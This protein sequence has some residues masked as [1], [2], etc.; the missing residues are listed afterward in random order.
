MDIEI[1][2]IEV[3]TEHKNSVLAYF[4]ATLASVIKIQNGTLAMSGDGQFCL[5]PFP[6]RGARHKVRFADTHDLGRLRM[7]VIEAYREAGGTQ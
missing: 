6:S 2:K 5:Y 3:L 4:D 1:T 7:A